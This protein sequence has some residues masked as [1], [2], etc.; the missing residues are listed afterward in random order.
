VKIVSAIPRSGRK[1]QWDRR[2]DLCLKPRHSK[3]DKPEEGWSVKNVRPNALIEE[4]DALIRGA[5]TAEAQAILKKLKKKDIPRDYWYEI[6]ALF[7]RAN[8]F[9]EAIL[10]LRPLIRP[11]KVILRESREVERVEYAASLLRLGAA[12]E[13]ATLLDSVSAESF[14]EVLMYQAMIHLQD[15][16]YDAAAPLLRQYLK[17]KL[18]PYETLV[19]KM[20]LALCLLFDGPFDEAETLLKDLLIATENTDAFLLV[21]GNTERLWGNLEVNRDRLPSALGHFQKSEQVL[22][23]VGGLAHFFSRKWI[24]ITEF[25]MS[26][27]QTTGIAAIEEEALRLRHWE[28]VRDLDFHRL[29]VNQSPALFHRLYFGSPQAQFRKRLTGKFPE[30]A[31][32]T[33]YYLPLGEGPNA[34]SP[35]VV[36]PTDGLKPGQMLHR[37]YFTLLSDFYQSFSVYTLFEK[38]FPEESYSPGSSEQRVHQAIK[39]L[40]T[41]FKTNRLPLTV[42]ATGN[43][44]ALDATSPCRLYI[45]QLEKPVSLNEYRLKKLREKLGPAFSTADACRVLAL[46]R[47]SV[48]ELVQYGISSQELEKVGLSAATKYRFRRS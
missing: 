4:V 20:N 48:T 39:R 10:L 6:A 23:N 3:A 29:V 25:L 26:P 34:D 2:P 21:R 28:T 36:V 24:A 11:G 37:L 42:K 18:T 15:W 31:L 43:S 32:P 9:T 38:L 45:E 30:V 27:S 47:R 12:K 22:R 35:K 5:R 1:Y 44:Y 13:A 8:L 14:A 19:G 40:R 16:N 41:W 33:E 17:R 7:R 46:S